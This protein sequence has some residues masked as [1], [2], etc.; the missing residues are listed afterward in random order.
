M[1]KPLGHHGFW[2]Q[3]GPEIWYFTVVETF[4]W[5]ATKYLIGWNTVWLRWHDHMTWFVLRS[6][7]SL[8]HGS[9]CNKC[10]TLLWMMGR[11]VPSVLPKNNPSDFECI[12]TFHVVIW[13]SLEPSATRHL[14]M[15]PYSP[16]IT[17]VT[18]SIKSKAFTRS[19]DS[20][21]HIIAR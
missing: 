9:S 12:S 4:F 5:L 8:S 18:T 3:L 19:Y 10:S 20:E 16:K 15:C 17:I 6:S 14:F 21:K 11:K 2:V 1:G 13:K 7:I